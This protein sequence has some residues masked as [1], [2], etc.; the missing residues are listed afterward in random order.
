ME[1]AI[2][3]IYASLP[4]LQEIFKSATTDRGGEFACFEKIE[5]DLGVKVHFADPFCP[6]QR[7]NNE[8]G[9]GLLRGFYLKGTKLS[10]VDKSHL[11]SSEALINNRP[12][13]CLGWISANEAFERAV[14][15][16]T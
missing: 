7:G 2:K 11:A 4:N 9:N 13:K 8:Y 14:S 12:R 10:I 16:L 1:T 6:H 3:L 15:Q 5:K